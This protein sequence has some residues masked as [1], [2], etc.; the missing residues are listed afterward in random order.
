M[1]VLKGTCTF[2]GGTW[3]GS[4]GPEEVLWG[5]VGG[6]SHIIWPRNRAGSKVT[7]PGVGCSYM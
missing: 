7:V 3:E 1:Q 6:P 4:T 2:W 5:S